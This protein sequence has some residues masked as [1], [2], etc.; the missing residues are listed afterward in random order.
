MRQGV[1]LFSCLRKIN[2][3]YEN[4]VLLWYNFVQIRYSH[5]SENEVEFEF[6]SL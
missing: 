3:F 4:K 6:F 5:S 2:L 1:S